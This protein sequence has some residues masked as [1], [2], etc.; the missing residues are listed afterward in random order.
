MTLYDILD[1]LGDINEAAR[2][3]TVSM[4]ASDIKTV[5]AIKSKLE[6]H[7]EPAVAFCEHI[8]PSEFLTE[9]EYED[10]KDR[11]S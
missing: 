8:S 4:L 2:Q 6:K 11:L 9:M 10:F 1:I 3:T 7:V 5:N